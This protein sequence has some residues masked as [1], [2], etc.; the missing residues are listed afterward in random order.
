MTISVR[1]AVP[2]SETMNVVHLSRNVNGIADSQ[3]LV[4]GQRAP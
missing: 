1:D 2:I 4:D 3:D